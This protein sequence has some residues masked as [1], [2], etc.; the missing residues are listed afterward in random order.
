MNQAIALFDDP[1][2]R[3][4]LLDAYLGNWAGVAGLAPVDPARAA[5][6]PEAMRAFNE[7]TP[8]HPSVPYYSIAGSADA[9]GDDLIEFAEADGMFPSF[10][11]EVLQ[12]VFGTR[13]HRFLGRAISLEMSVERAGLIGTLLNVTPLSTLINYRIEGTSVLRDNPAP[14]DLV[15]TAAS[16]HCI[17][18]GF[19]PL[20]TYP[21]NHSALK[22]PRT[23]DL[24]LNQIRSL[25][26]VGMGGGRR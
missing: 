12:S 22:R 19:V 14:N 21:N 11:P 20:Q 8:K 17:E 26:P 25:Y 6:T 15:S 4:A 5:Q 2:V 13:I 7:R 24:I 10:A 18:C 1:D 3:A 9:N 23:I 16:T